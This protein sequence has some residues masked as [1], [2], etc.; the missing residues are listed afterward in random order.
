MVTMDG[1]GEDKPEDLP[2][3]LERLLSNP[4]KRRLL[5][6]ARRT[7]RQE[8]LTFKALHIGFKSVFRLLPGASYRRETTRP[9]G[10]GSH[11]T[12]SSTRTSISATVQ[13]PEPLAACRLRAVRRGRRYAG[14]SRMGYFRLAIHGMRMLM[15]FMDRIAVR[16]LAA[17]AAA[18]L[19]GMGIAVG[20]A[21]RW[22]RVEWA[23]A[24]TLAE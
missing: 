5:V 9:T 12:R 24:P 13:P 23:G 16:A 14:E 1:D 19:L 18:V 10:A 2:R 15:P 3:L 11:G 17:A 7:R 20:T 8:S 22:V 21:G 4:G 6:L